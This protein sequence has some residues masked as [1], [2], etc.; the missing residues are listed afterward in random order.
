MDK[1]YYNLV[2]VSRIINKREKINKQDYDLLRYFLEKMNR[3]LDVLD[4]T[5]YDIEGP[6]DIGLA[7]AIENKLEEATK[8]VEESGFG[9]QGDEF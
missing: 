7:E 4:T 1:F 6:P 3:K 9:I 5:S 8:V 2:N